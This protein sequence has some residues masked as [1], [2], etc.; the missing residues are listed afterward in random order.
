MGAG[1]ED[2]LASHLE[3]PPGADVERWMVGVAIVLGKGGSRLKEIGTRARAGI[4]ELTGKTVH[5][6]LHVKVKEDWAEDRAVY[7]DSGLDW[8]E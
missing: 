2:E 5:L 6:F 7:R 4:G 8:V 3:K 1:D